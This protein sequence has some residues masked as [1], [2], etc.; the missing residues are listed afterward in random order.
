MYAGYQHV[1]TL[2]YNEDGELVATVYPAQGLR[3]TTWIETS[4]AGGRL[5][6][7]AETVQQPTLA[8]DIEVEGNLVPPVHIS[9]RV[10]HRIR[11]SA[12]SEFGSARPPVTVAA[13]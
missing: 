10:G 7:V 1:Y 9:A 2:V 8:V 6:G 3:E 4:C 13:G 12:A 5:R 11:L